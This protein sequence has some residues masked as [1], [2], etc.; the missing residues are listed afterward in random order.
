[1]RFGMSRLGRYGDWATCVEGIFVTIVIEG[2]KA[3]SRGRGLVSQ[4]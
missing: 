4:A 3:K 1:M 2:V